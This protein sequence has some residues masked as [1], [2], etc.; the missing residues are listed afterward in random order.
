M[1]LVTRK[2]M[3]G[4]EGKKDKKKALEESSIKDYGLKDRL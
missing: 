4:E 1:I 2:K 3:T